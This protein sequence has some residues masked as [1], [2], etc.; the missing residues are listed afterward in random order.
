[1]ST[2]P[3]EKG[4]QK[5]WFGSESDYFDRIRIRSEH[6]GIKSESRKY[7]FKFQFF[8]KFKTQ[9]Y[10][11]ENLNLIRENCMPL[12]YIRQG[13]MELFQCFTKLLT[14]PGFFVKGSI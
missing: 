10:S 11:S 13:W 4:T 1:M 9:L 7:H 8:F 5:Q 14:G 3:K 6:P 2:E 12:L